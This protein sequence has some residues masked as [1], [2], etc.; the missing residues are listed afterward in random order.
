MY[1]TP[2]IIASFDEDQI[3]GEARGESGSQDS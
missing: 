1:S 2:Q 3:L